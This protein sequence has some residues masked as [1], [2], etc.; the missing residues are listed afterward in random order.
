VLACPVA[1]TGFAARRVLYFVEIE[2]LVT[3]VCHADSA[4]AGDGHP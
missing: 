1:G 3:Q 4:G 2:H